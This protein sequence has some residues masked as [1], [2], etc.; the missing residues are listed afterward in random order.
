MPEFTTGDINEIK[1]RAGE[2]SG[3]PDIQPGTG[4][5]LL[6]ILE[7]SGTAART[8]SL[9]GLSETKVRS[10]IREAGPEPPHALAEVEGKAAQYAASL[11]GKAP[12]SLHVLAALAT[13]RDSQAHQILRGAGLNTDV[14]RN[15]A[16]RCLTNGFTREHGVPTE[17]TPRA[18]EPP[19]RA[20]PWMDAEALP[21]P[22]QLKIPPASSRPGKPL[23]PRTPPAVGALDSEP[24]PRRPIKLKR[25]VGLNLE[26]AQR[27]LLEKR[28]G[29]AQPL[30]FEPIEEQLPEPVPLEPTAIE[31]QPLIVPAEPLPEPIPEADN[32]FELA[33]RDY[34]LLSSL[35]RNLTLEAEAG[36]LDGIVGREH[37][38]EKM[39][40]ILNKRRAN[41]PCLIGPPG[42]GKT[43]VVEG[44]ALRIV[45]NEA[46]GLERRVIIEIR[47]GDL[48]SGTSL[49]GALSERLAEMRAE[50]VASNGRVILF[51]DEFHS[52]L[53]SNDGAEA[54]QELK[55][56]L[57][58][59]ELPCIAATTRT[60]YAQQIE[61]DPA[62]ARRFT[63]VEVVEPD[64]GEAVA[65]LE[66][67]APLYSEHHQVSFAPEAL[68]AA[69]QL[70]ARYVPE[71]ALPD[72]AL[73][74]LDLAGARA[75]RRG[76]E[77]VSRIEVAQVLAEQ[78]GV[79]AERLTIGDR[80]RLLRLEDE[81]AR[82]VVG[83]EHVLAAL[84]ETLRRNA[85]GFR[86]GRPIGSFLFLGPTGVGKTE[87]AKALAD[88]LFPGGDALVRLDMTEFSEAH[89]VARLV[90]APPGYVG[91]EDGGQLTEAV[92]RRPYCLVLLDEIEKAHREVIQILLQILDDGRLTDSKG[93]TVVL[94]N[95]VIAM[96][97]NLG[98]D[99]R[100]IGSRSK[101]VGFGAGSSE[102]AASDV[103]EAILEAA[104]GALPAE[105]WNRIDEPLVFAPLEREQVAAIARMMIDRVSEQLG[106]EH[107]ITLD[108][109]PEAIEALL[110]AGGYD[111]QLGARPMR[112]T[113]QR[114]VEGPVAKLVL[115]DELSPGDV[116]AIGTGD[117][118]QL[119]FD[120]TEA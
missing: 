4:H 113:I 69:V 114:L 32:G 12:S 85:A 70:S 64:E 104:R 44:L 48:L 82:R 74:L 96:T 89:A 42:V 19:R 103:S 28:V 95:A 86:T 115:A 54:I 94:E 117:D 29:G 10:G 73:A 41:S 68:T 101:R 30:P 97:S 52:L 1:Q 49:R 36:K 7:G 107:G 27:K 71:R 112:R 58:R 111:S 116:V 50:V 63:T 56:A 119:T 16:L 35:G 37:E 22:E 18:D 80:E 40:D 21:L 87:T 75:R 91:H 108:T 25:G 53:A 110:D 45:N 24:E 9:R 99:L 46:P 20:H 93:R 13:V 6:A 118:D 11:G 84:G 67:L 5:L 31:E 33:R 57:G 34:P 88:L 78:I 51:F 62:L 120:V 23:P 90:G 17:D 66:G 72:K 38:T 76:A 14:I 3:D 106:R 43:A 92:R 2:L 61:A 65:I 100:E 77:D 55:E 79:P 109:A 81:L 8:L 26:Q 83:H 39:A 59:G 15:Q 98:A 60:E 47:P 105:L 102:P